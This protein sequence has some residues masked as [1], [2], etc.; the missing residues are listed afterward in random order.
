MARMLRGLFVAG[1][2]GGMVIVGGNSM[3]QGGDGAGGGAAAG[4][5]KI[6]KTDSTS[7]IGK[8]CKDGGIKAAKAAM[9]A[10]LKKAKGN[11]V[12]FDC[13]DCHMDE[14]NALTD[15]AGDKFKKLLAAAEK[16]S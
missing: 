7:P 8:A 15:D 12:K 13:D 9:K 2:I 6:T 16:A 5:C 11:G 10:L 1:I 14:S 4:A 3:A